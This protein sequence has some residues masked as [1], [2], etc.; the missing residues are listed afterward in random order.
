MQT[1]VQN[2]VEI[3]WKHGKLQGKTCS[4]NIYLSSKNG[5]HIKIS[6]CNK[7]DFNKNDSCLGS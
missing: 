3:K 4:K 6:I 2:Q 7:I 5:L 1:I